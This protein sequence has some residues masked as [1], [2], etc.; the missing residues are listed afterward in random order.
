MRDVNAATFRRV[1]RLLNPNATDRPSLMGDSSQ[2]PPIL[3]NA[4]FQPTIPLPMATF[5]A[6]RSSPAQYFC[7]RS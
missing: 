1:D 4:A 5:L 2:C 6:T 3:P 7:A